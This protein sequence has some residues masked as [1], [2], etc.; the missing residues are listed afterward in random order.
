MT[1]L[2]IACQEGHAEVVTQLIAANADLDQAT[3]AG[4]TPLMMACGRGYTNI[5]TINKSCFTSMPREPDRAC[6]GFTAP[7]KP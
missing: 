2:Y 3:D 1:A 5:K 6:R 7:P 4:A